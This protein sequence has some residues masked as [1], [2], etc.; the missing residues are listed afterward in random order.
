MTRSSRW[1]AAGPRRSKA[2]LSQRPARPRAT[3]LALTY[4]AQFPRRLPRPHPGRGRRR[5][6]PA[7]VRLGERQ[8]SRCSD[9]SAVERRTSRQLRL[10]TYRQ[11]GLMSLSEVV[12]VLENFGLPRARGNPDR[13]CRRASA[14]S[15]ISRSRSRTKTMSN[16][17]S[18][19][20][21]KSSARSP[22][23]CAG[24]PKM[25]SSTSLSSTPGSKPRRWCG[26]APGSATC[27]RPAAAFGLLTVV[28]ALRRAPRTRP[29]P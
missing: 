23:S 7:P 6:H 25:T 18:R 12:P 8:R 9:L 15:T 13:A 16:R 4:V 1:S 5:G 11:G 17:S 27:A 3:R 21:A 29:A 28:D 2:S 19:G 22:M 10:K 14:T 26:C 20:S 24:R